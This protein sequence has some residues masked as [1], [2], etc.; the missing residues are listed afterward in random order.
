[1]Q[2]DPREIALAAIAETSTACS[3]YKERRILAEAYLAALATLDAGGAA[4]ANASI[5]E[6]CPMRSEA[7]P[8]Q[9]LGPMSDLRV[10]HFQELIRRGHY[11]G[12]NYTR[13]LLHEIFR[14]RRY[15]TGYSLEELDR[16]VAALELGKMDKY[17]TG[18][19]E[20]IRRRT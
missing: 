20:M 19:K 10:Q 1:M 12:P 13:E 18:R 7:I 16:R 3:A 6:D 15:Q 9:Q 4:I 2:H 5:L 17:D 14:C 8:N 11:I